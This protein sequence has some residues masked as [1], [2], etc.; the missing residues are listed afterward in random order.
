[1]YRLA[2]GKNPRPHCVISWHGSGSVLC[3]RG[4]QSQMLTE[5]AVIP[6]ITAQAKFF[7]R[8][9]QKF[10]F[11]A[12]RLPD[13]GPSLDFGQKL[14]LRR[15]FEELK[16]AHTTGLVVTE[17]QAQP[18]LDIAAQAGVAAML[19]TPACAP[20]SVR[21]AAMERG[22]FA[23]RAYRRDL[24]RASRGVCLHHRLSDLAGRATRRRFHEGSGQDA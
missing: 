24:S 18:V 3:D 4:T 9:G 8:S 1:M 11:K 15:R 14:A 22:S 21:R 7:S 13:V 17:A 16:L 2:T 6:T 23:R 10:F 5:T 20:R 12:M 19:D